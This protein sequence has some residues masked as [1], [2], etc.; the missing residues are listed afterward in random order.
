MED[1]GIKMVAFSIS[2]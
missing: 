2:F 1:T